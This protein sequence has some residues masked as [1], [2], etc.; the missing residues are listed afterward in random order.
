MIRALFS[1]LPFGSPMLRNMGWN[2]LGQLAPMLAALLSIPLLVSKIGDERFGLLA[3]G[4]MLIGYFSVFDLGLGRALTQ[5]IASRRAR[6]EPVFDIIN[7][8]LA[9]MFALGTLAALLL[10]LGSDYLVYSLLKIAPALR[11][12]AKTSLLWLAPAMP[13]VVVATG[14]RGVLEAVQAFKL[15]NL[16]RTPVG[17]LTFVAPL[18]ALPFSHSLV[19]FFAILSVL[20]LLTLVAFVWACYRAMPG[21]G[22]G[23][24]SLQPLPD[25]L[26]FGGWMTISNLISPLMVNM[27]RL[28]IG[29]VLSMSA[30][31]FYS[32]P[33]EMILRA[34]VVPSAIA[35]V[36]FPVFAASNAAASERVFWQS[37]RSVAACMALMLLLVWPFAEPVLR[38]WLNDDYARNST[39]VLRWLALGV[40]FN[41][42]AYIPYSWVQGIG[43]S[44]ITAQFHML[45]LVI[46][47]PLL[48]ACVHWQGI[49]GVA[50]A[51]TVRAILDAACLFG[52]T[53]PRLKQS[54]QTCAGAS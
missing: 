12:E 36:C 53:L 30:V 24:I 33:H 18:A 16:V 51:W 11:P 54:V 52:Y 42:L 47:A 15:S 23:R 7:S 48:Y 31:S 43:Q 45:E 46:Y 26:R 32:T 8:A 13:L 9:L 29:A 28:L 38:W 20:R 41:G 34:L 50:I 27:D 1:R 49:V 17:V 40:A 39:P 37:V 5:S 4:W 22:S 35:G 25:L 21:F 10:W 2:L 44:R 14:L 3:I 6:G 19:P